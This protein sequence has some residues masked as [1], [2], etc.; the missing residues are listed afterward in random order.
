MEALEDMRKGITKMQEASGIGAETTQAMAALTQELTVGI[1]K[2][3]RDVDASMRSVGSALL[4]FSAD[5]LWKMMAVSSLGLLL[6]IACAAI[7]IRII[8]RVL[9]Q[10]GAFASAVAKGDF[11]YNLNSREKG[12]IGLVINS[13]RAIPKALEGLIAQ[14]HDMAERIASGYLRHRLDPAALPGSFSGLAASVNSVSE[15]YSNLLDAINM[16]IMACDKDNSIL[17]LNKGGQEVLGGNY[18][19]EKCASHLNAKECGTYNCL[20]LCAMEKNAS[21]VA[22][23]TLNVR[24]K[25]ME[26]GVTAIPLRNQRGEV[27]GYAELIVDLTEIKDRQAKVLNVVAGASVIAD[28]VA[29]A[30]EELAAQVE[31]ISRGA[32]MQHDRVSA[33]ATAMEEMNSTVLE[34]ARNAGSASEQSEGTRDKAE[35]GASLVKQVVSS[36]NAVNNVATTLRDNMTELGRKAESIGDVMNVIADIADQTNLLALNAAIEAARAGEAGRGFAVVADEVR[37]LAEKTMCAT[38]E[39]GENIQAIQQSAQVNMVEVENAVASIHEANTLANSS[40]VALQEIVDIASL[41][42]ATV[43]SI[44][45]AAEQQSLTSEEINRA[46]EEINRVV[47]DTSE[48]MVQSSAAVQ[49]LS[50]VAQ[51]LKV[52]MDELR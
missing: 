20:G 23:V 5:T 11:S 46:I 25:K 29:S 43:A 40:G 37:K 3:N 6:G 26:A 34:V 7:I 45:T 28:R 13:M 15:A 35:Q 9:G 51:E 14:A 36:I 48:S 18:V 49:D 31:Q 32:E 21:H 22:E 33:T 12:E 16:P 42:S 4:E 41:S 47:G 50:K 1:G 39:V 10:L 30:S 2:L 27:V 44:A 38:H 19:K 17:Y 52:V 24:G 8:T